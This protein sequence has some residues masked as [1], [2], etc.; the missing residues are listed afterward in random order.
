MIHV[1][2]AHRPRPSRDSRSPGALASRPM[3]AA[4]G[5]TLARGA[6]EGSNADL[7]ARPR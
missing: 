5:S 6:G 3:A 4:S 2:A 7:R 1:V